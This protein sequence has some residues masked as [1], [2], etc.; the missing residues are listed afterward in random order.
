VQPRGS[1]PESKIYKRYEVRFAITS[2][3]SNGNASEPS[4]A[5]FARTSFS[6]PHRDGGGRSGAGC[7]YFESWIGTVLH[8]SI[9]VLGVKPDLRIDGA[10]Q[11]VSAEQLVQNHDTRAF[12][13]AENYE[14]FYRSFLF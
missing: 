11:N 4:F 7:A 1:I 13:N 8:E 6:G 9:H 5:V 2:K 3:Y 10:N 12:T 14:W